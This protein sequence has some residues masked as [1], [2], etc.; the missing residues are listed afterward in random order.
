[1]SHPILGGYVVFL[2]CFEIMF[3]S[4]VFVIGTLISLERSKRVFRN[5]DEFT[6]EIVRTLA[7]SFLAI[8]MQ[9]PIFEHSG[10]QSE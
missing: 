3:Q 9:L 10:R 8:A 7:K 6:T 2:I 4:L 5:K 1:M